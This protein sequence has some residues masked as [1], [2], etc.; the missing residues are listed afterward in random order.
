MPFKKLHKHEQGFRHLQF[1][2]YSEKSQYYFKPQIISLRKI[3]T[4]CSEQRVGDVD[5][6]KQDRFAP[7]GY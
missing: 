2:K 4:A 7:S 6:E 1:E 5:E 3:I